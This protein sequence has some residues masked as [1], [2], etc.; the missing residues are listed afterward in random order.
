MN[1]FSKNLQWRFC[2]ELPAVRPGYQGEPSRTL[3]W[4][5]FHLEPTQVPL[6]TL[7]TLVQ[8]RMLTWLAWCLERHQSVKE[9]ACWYCSPFIYSNLPSASPAE[10]TRKETQKMSPASVLPVRGQSSSACR[11]PAGNGTAER[12]LRTVRAE[13]DISVRKCSR[14][15]HPDIATPHLQPSTCEML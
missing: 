10:T 15:L 9:E 7:F 13:H 2:Q 14:W 4:F 6:R 12:T 3:P 8:L 11:R 1:I 5:T